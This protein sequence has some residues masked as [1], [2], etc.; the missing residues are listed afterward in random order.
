[1]WFILWHF[2]HFDYTS[3]HTISMWYSRIT[4]FSAVNTHRIKVHQFSCCVFLVLIQSLEFNVTRWLGI[5]CEGAYNCV[6]IV[7][8][9]SN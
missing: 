7:G 8:S 6:K 2:Q 1:V 9:N 3:A 5:I 4:L